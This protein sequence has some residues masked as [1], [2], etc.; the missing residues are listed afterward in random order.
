MPKIIFR[1]PYLDKLVCEQV[2]FPAMEYDSDTS[3]SLCIL[4]LQDRENTVFYEANWLL[5]HDMGYVELIGTSYE[6]ENDSALFAGNVFS[7]AVSP[8]QKYLAT[9]MEGEGSNW[10]EIIDLQ[11][12]LTQKK[13][14]I[15]QSVYG[16]PGLVY[17]K[18]W[19]GEKLVIE[20][21]INLLKLNNGGEL[22]FEDI[23]ENNFTEMY[24]FDPKT[25][26]YEKYKTK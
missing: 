26:H 21:D 20:S 25:N 3:G 12:L 10:I 5:V 19:Q 13:I 22:N 7:M 17:I 4:L 14:N 1:E 16:F 24:L 18:W 8:N 11:K 2:R 9:E 6:E 23:E 15:I